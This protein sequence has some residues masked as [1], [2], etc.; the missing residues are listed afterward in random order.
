MHTSKTY[1]KSTQLPRPALCPDRQNLRNLTRHAQYSRRSLQ[2]AQP[3]IPNQILIEQR[4]A[5]RNQPADPPRDAQTVPAIL[6]HQT[7]NRNI[8]NQ[9]KRRLAV[10]AEREPVAHVIA[11]ADEVCAG[12]EQVG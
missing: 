3:L 2:Q 6:E 5:R 4:C 7:R 1:R 11:Q 8:L 10:C 12:L 9:N